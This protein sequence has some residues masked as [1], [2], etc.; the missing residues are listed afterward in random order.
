MLLMSL[1]AMALAWW[2][3]HCALAMTRERLHTAELSLAMERRKSRTAA[4]DKVVQS[5]RQDNFF[6]RLAD[7]CDAVDFDPKKA[8]QNLRNYVGTSLVLS[9]SYGTDEAILVFQKELAR[10]QINKSR[11]NHVHLRNSDVSKAG[12]DVL[13]TFPNI[14]FV[15]LADCE[16]IGDAAMA[17]LAAMPCLRKVDLQ[18]TQVTREGVARLEDAHPKCFIYYR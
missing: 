16:Q 13:A 7:G 5:A 14:R 3:D 4:N 8:A 10:Q 9:D 17:S 11:L 18:E 15:D 6:L 12:L 2:L 1:A